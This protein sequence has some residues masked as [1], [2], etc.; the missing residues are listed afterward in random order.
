[1]LTDRQRKIRVNKIIK[2]MEAAGPE[3][4]DMNYYIR[5]PDEHA[6]KS[7]PEAIHSCGTTACIAGFAV[8]AS[9][10]WET[11]EQRFSAYTVSDFAVGQAYLGLTYEE[12]SH[13]FRSNWSANMYEAVA[14][15]KHYAETGNVEW[16]RD[17]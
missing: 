11:H 6:S 3:H 16:Q 5:M 15:L 13:L 9:K 17:K 7:L 14:T 8:I 2:L 4:F 12:A 10:L 1:M